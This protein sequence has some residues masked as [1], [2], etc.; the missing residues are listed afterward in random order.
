MYR[1]VSLIIIS[2]PFVSIRIV[3]CDDRIVS[4][5]VDGSIRK[6]VYSKGTLWRIHVVKNLELTPI[7]QYFYS[8]W[9]HCHQQGFS[10]KYRRIVVFLI[11]FFSGF[12][13]SKYSIFPLK[14]LNNHN[15]KYKLNILTKSNLKYEVMKVKFH[16]TVQNSTYCT[17]RKLNTSRDTLS[18]RDPCWRQRLK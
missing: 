10:P 4:S 18:S 9:Y 7:R 5:L 14:I 1:I 17:Y 11:T 15:K 12:I 6:P 2:P 16:R 8:T 13:S 3:S